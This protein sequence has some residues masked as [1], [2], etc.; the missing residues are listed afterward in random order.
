MNSYVNRYFL[1]EYKMTYE[2]FRHIEMG[3]KKL[4]KKNKDSSKK[5]IRI[6]KK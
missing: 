4:L 1:D 2:E 5:L 6:R 3:R